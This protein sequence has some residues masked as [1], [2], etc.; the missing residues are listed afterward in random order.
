MLIAPGWQNVLV[1]ESGNYIKPNPSVLAQYADLANPNL[2]A[3]LLKPQ[4]SRSKVSMRQWQHKLRL[5]KEAQPDQSL[6]RSGPFLFSPM[7]SG[8]AGGCVAGKSLCGLYHR[9]CKV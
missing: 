9:N 1:L 2:H 3:W 6:K 8:W 4:L 7:V 5:L